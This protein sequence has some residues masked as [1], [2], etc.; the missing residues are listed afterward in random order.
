MNRKYI[1]PILTILAVSIIY[2]V[3]SYLDEKEREPL[4]KEAKELKET[5]RILVMIEV[6]FAQQE[7]V[8]FLKK[9]LLKLF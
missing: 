3:N 4:I 6:I 2:I 9:R 7:I 5:T 8:S 1:Y